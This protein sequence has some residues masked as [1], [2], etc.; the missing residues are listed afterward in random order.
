ML[1]N[2]GSPVRAQHVDSPEALEKLLQEKSWDL[3][4]GA[5]NTKNIA[6]SDAIKQIRRLNKD[7]PLVLQTDRPGTVAVVEGLKFGAVDVVTLDEDQ[8][9]LYVIQ[10]ELANRDEREKRRVSE[11]R[12]Y[13]IAR[14]NQQLLDS[15]RDAI[16]FVQDGMFLYAN[17]S[18]SELLGHETTED[19]ECMPVIDMVAKNDHDKVKRFLKEFL[20][21]GSDVDATV[22]SMSSMMMDGSTKALNIEVRKA[23]YDEESCFQFLV[24]SRPA[25]NEELEA[26]LEQIKNQDVATGLYN[27]KYLIGVLDDIVDA[28]IAKRYDSSLFHIGVDDFIETV[29]EKL[30]VASADIVI[31]TIATYIKSL[32]YDNETLCRFSEDGFLLLAPKTGANKALERAESICKK[33]RDFVV[34][35]DGSTLQ[36]NYFVGIALITETSTNS[37]IP[38]D[39]VIKALNLVQQLAEKDPNIL[40]KIYEPEVKTPSSKKDISLMVQNALNSGKFKLLFQP[41]LSLRGSSKE[42]YEVLLRMLGDD[43]DEISPNDFLT[44]AAKIGAT[45]KL[46]RWVILESI[47]IL[48]SHR[49]K[50][51][52]THLILN[53][54]RE[55]MLD[56][57]LPPWLAVA[58]KAA[59]LPP[60]AIIFQLKEIDINDHLNVANTFTKQL[61]DL[62]SECCISHFGCSLNPFNAIKHTTVS[63]IKVDG[64]FTQDLQNNNDEENSLNELIG[65]LHQHDKITIVPFVENAS[66][67]SKLWQSGVHYIQGFY[68]QEPAAHLNYDFDMES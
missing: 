20:I 40:A 32:T 17:E 27:K 24:K 42:H 25:E 51:N 44:T 49:E 38:I 47:K 11:R 26:Q 65:E 15:S 37:E 6:P 58:F 57:T 2:A 31:G 50:G 60:S 45:T 29:Q 46:D 7:V 41:I 28:A 54:S 13:E 68:L 33:L 5:D 21:K 66:I 36:F 23:N 43:G 63:Y 30:G 8:H 61:T 22:L 48:S 62:G 10:R 3:M 59:K 55:S 64:S 19:L 35:V 14:R 18:F 67:L 16:A 53:L 4:I 9:L 34:D 39:H 52:S 1:H 12:F 56:A